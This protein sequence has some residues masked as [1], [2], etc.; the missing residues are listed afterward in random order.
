[1]NPKTTEQRV[2][3]ILTGI[4]FAIYFGILIATGVTMLRYPG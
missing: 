2:L 4:A 3:Y 1:M